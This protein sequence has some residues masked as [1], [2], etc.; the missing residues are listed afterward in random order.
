MRCS[1]ARSRA[2]AGAPRPARATRP[3]RRAA[4]R[5]ALGDPGRLATS[6]V[7]CGC[8]LR[9]AN[10]VL[11]PPVSGAAGAAADPSPSLKAPASAAGNAHPS[12]A[13]EPVPGWLLA[14]AQPRT[15]QTT[16]A[17]A[18]RQRW[19][20][21][22]ER[23]AP[24]PRRCWRRGWRSSAAAGTRRTRR[25][26]RTCAHWRS[27]WAWPARSTLPSTRPSARR[28]AR[29]PCINGALQRGA[30]R[31]PGARRAR[32]ARG[33]AGAPDMRVPGPLPRSAGHAHWAASGRP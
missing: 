9:V 18:R 21:R 1:C 22:R 7:L 19:P 27:S 20:P 2:R 13:P 23:R 24:P 8:C 5:V 25:A 10:P 15:P 14:T 33:P 3:T 29:A 6:F 26:W 4:L 31:A 11:F 16:S 30:P 28:A 32:P 17:R 12:G